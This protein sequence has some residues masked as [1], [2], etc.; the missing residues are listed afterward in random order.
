MPGRVAIV[1]HYFL[2][3]IGGIEEVARAQ[4]TSLAQ[5]GHLVTVLT[6]SHREGMPRHER[7]DDYTVRRAKTLNVFERWLGVPFPIVSPMFLL[8]MVREAR[9]AEILH[10]H[11]VFYTTS[12]IGF[13]AAL[14]CRKPF[15]LTQHVALV[16]HPSHLVMAV[17]RT[18]YRLVGRAMLRK[19]RAIIVYNAN[20]RDFVTGIGAKPSRVFMN[21]NGIDTDWF[22]PIAPEKKKDLRVQYGL[23]AERPIVLFVG[24]LV[25]KK[26]YDLVVDSASEYHTTLMVGEGAPVQPNSSQVVLFGPA[27]RLQLRD[28]YRLSDVFVFPAVGELFTLV[29]QE[30]MSSGLPIVTTDDPGYEDYELDRSLIALV[31]RNCVAIAH[32]VRQIL[33]SG[34]LRAEMSDYSRQLALQRFSW[35]E[36]YPREY[37][38]Y[39]LT[40]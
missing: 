13:L 31:P 10:I 30:A 19:A 4:A 8:T 28:L 1:T 18:V 20:V 14:L 40:R 34:R 11:D 33:E 7:S 32:A 5:R 27:T 29:M 9:R 39:Q 3:H 25:P 22:S 37:A 23:A 36:N 12:H 35:D 21:H 15:Y 17:Q 2:P 38:I 24:R 26:G 6:C 16:E